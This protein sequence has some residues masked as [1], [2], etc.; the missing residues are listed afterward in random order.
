MCYS[1]LPSATRKFLKHVKDTGQVSYPQLY[2]TLWIRLISLP[3]SMH[4]LKPSYITDN[5]TA[6]LAL[7]STTRGSICVALES[8]SDRQIKDQENPSSILCL[9][10]RS[11]SSLSYNCKDKITN[12]VLVI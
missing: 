3:S 8:T 2:I 9:T 6:I 5:A 7:H 4:G 12:Y 1:S 10:R 11:F